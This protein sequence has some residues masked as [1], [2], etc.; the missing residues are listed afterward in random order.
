[1]GNLIGNYPYFV[2]S[3][4]V[5]IDAGGSKA[6]KE[7]TKYSVGMTPFTSSNPPDEAVQL[8]GKWA[9]TGVWLDYEAP[10]YSTSL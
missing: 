2:Y 8:V 5:P 7:E 10:P 6:R 4:F 1:M 9:I 3:P